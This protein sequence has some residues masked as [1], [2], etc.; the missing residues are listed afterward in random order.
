M[1]DREIYTAEQSR[2]PQRPDYA[3][4]RP[5]QHLGLT[6]SLPSFFSPHLSSSSSL[7]CNSHPTMKNTKTKNT[8]LNNNNSSDIKN[9]GLKKII[10][11]KEYFLSNIP[12]FR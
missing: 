12:M 7:L 9:K 2:A 8:L 6:L 11:Y 3:Y 1:E 5:P 4:F 10:N